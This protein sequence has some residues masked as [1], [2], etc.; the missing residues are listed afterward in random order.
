[1]SC[2]SVNKFENDCGLALLRFL[3]AKSIIKH[4]WSHFPSLLSPCT[5]LLSRIDLDELMKKDEPPLYF[6][7][8]LEEFEYAFNDRKYH[9]EWRFL[10]TVWNG[11]YHVMIVSVRSIIIV[12]GRL[13]TLSQIMVLCICH[14][15]S[16]TCSCFHR[17]WSKICINFLLTPPGLFWFHVPNI[18]QGFGFYTNVHTDTQMCVYVWAS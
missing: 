5:D 18:L 7:R 14:G 1:M 13:Q 2:L 6:P 9:S 11:H 3:R 8:T 4:Y 12:S 17:C 15:L 10:L 16:V